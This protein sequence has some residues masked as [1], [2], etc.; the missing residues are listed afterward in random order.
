M[1]PTEIKLSILDLAMKG[2]WIMIVLA[3]LSIIAVY[4]FIERFIVVKRATNF[5]KSFMDRIR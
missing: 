5:D 4:I 3:V 2:G 1:Q